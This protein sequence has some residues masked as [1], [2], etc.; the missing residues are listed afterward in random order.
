TS[1]PEAGRRCWGGAA[2]VSLFAGRF[3]EARRLW[4]DA[5]AVAEQPCVY[6]AS[7]AL[8]AAYGGDRTGAVELV[9]RALDAERARPCTAHRAF[10]RYA[11]GEALAADDPAPAGTAY[12]SAIVLARGCGAGF[13]EGVALVGQASVWESTGDLDAAVRG[14][15]ALLDYWNRTGNATQ[16]WTTIRNV[17]RL[18]ADHGRVADASLLRAAADGA[19]SASRLT[20][21]ES[22]RDARERAQLADRLG[23]ETVTALEERARTLTAAGASAV[24]RAA[25]DDVPAG[26]P[27]CS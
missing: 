1:D 23:A 25:L 17:A 10:A 7:A 15:R 24:A 20:G 18:L 3:D 6:L 26:Q 13:V 12:A 2:A 5:A 22:E 8:A 14:Y 9:R 21:A 27:Q 11:E 4:T 19:A 16:L